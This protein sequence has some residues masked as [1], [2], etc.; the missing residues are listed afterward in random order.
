MTRARFVAALA[1]A[2][3]FGCGGAPAPKPPPSIAPPKVEPGSIDVLSLV[4][5]APKRALANGAVALSHDVTRPDDPKR[6]I[7]DAAAARPSERRHRLAHV[8]RTCS[9]EP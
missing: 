5:D 6:L 1:L 4:G 7:G 9:D 8:R 3:F 2:G